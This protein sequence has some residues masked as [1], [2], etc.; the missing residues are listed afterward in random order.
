MKHHKH[1]LSPRWQSQEL[2]DVPVRVP[3]PSYRRFCRWL[4]GELDRLVARWAH[5]AAPSALYC[6]RF[7]SRFRAPKPE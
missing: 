1:N 4:D 3:A 6:P 7:R 5:A 2:A